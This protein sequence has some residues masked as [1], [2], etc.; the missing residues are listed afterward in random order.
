MRALREGTGI[1][2]TKR[3][4]TAYVKKKPSKLEFEVKFAENRLRYSDEFKIL[5]HKKGR[6][7]WGWLRSNELCTYCGLLS[8]SIVSTL[9]LKS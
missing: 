3:R 1:T 8:V 4:L 2:F 6:C 5:V 9:Q 7:L